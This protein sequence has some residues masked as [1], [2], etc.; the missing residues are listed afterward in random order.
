M[1]DI[2]STYPFGSASYRSGG[3]I[4]T[5]WSVAHILPVV[6]SVLFGPIIDAGTL[7]AT[8]AKHG[9]AT[10]VSSDRFQSCCHRARL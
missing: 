6:Y 8:S 1:S 4:L 2:N 9:P 5:R 10:I 3:G 7:S